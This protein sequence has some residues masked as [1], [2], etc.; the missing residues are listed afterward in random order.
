MPVFIPLRTRGP[1]HRVERRLHLHDQIQI[2]GLQ[3]WAPA[4]GWDFLHQR[5]PCLVGPTP[6]SVGRLLLILS[7][8]C[9]C[10]RGMCVWYICGAC[11]CM[12]V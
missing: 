12:R 2:K 3:F 8:V 6:S 11:V 4:A 9:V 7:M 10:A 5:P 1:G